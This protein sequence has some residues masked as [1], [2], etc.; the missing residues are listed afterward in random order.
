[1]STLRSLTPRGVIG[2]KLGVDIRVAEAGRTRI[3]FIS[4]IAWPVGS[5]RRPGG[6]GG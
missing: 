4:A 1:L 6:A 2:G 5:C 3:G